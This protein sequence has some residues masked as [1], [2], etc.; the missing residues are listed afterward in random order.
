MTIEV[1]RYLGVAP[2]DLR[3]VNVKWTNWATALMNARADLEEKRA[4]KPDQAFR[5]A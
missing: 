4:R 2:W 1:A 5:D 3:R